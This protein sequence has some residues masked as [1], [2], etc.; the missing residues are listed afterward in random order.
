[1]PGKILEDALTEKI[2]PKILE[3]TKKRAMKLIEILYSFS[4]II[5][6]KRVT[7]I[8]KDILVSYC[9]NSNPLN[10]AKR[11]LVNAVNIT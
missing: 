5:A 8:I 2:R 1:M 4:T 11:K 6:T 10:K 9:N 3:K 7:L